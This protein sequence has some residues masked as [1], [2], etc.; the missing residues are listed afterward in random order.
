MR[1]RSNGKVAI[2]GNNRFLED[3]FMPI[4]SDTDYFFVGHA[5]HDK[6]IRDNDYLNRFNRNESEL[7]LLEIH[8][9]ETREERYPSYV[10]WLKTLDAVKLMHKKHDDIIF[11]MRY[12]KAEVEDHFKRYTKMQLKY[13]MS[14]FAYMVAWCIYVGYKRIELYGINM[15][16]GDDYIQKYNFEFWLGMAMGEGI[17]VALTPQCD[18]LRCKDYGYEVNNTLGVY[19]QRAI[20]ATSLCTLVTLNNIAADLCMIDISDTRDSVIRDTILTRIAN[21]KD[22]IARLYID[23]TKFMKEILDRHGIDIKTQK[24]DEGDK[25]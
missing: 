2:V 10:E 22:N 4:N 5:L 24:F 13:F 3:E 16:F 19:Q 8:S 7:M 9:R 14:S 21:V 6:C 18:L 20:K 25:D 17:E 11:S 23:N 12:P 1:K 15:V